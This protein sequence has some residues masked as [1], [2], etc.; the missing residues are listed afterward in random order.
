MFRWVLFDVFAQEMKNGYQPLGESSRSKCIFRNSRGLF[1]LCIYHVPFVRC[2]TSTTRTHKRIGYVNGI[3]VISIIK[4]AKY[5][6]Q[7]F[8]LCIKIYCFDCELQQKTFI[9]AL[10]FFFFWLF[11]FLG[12]LA[13]GLSSIRE[14]RAQDVIRLWYE[15]NESFSFLHIEYMYS[16]RSQFGHPKKKKKLNKNLPFN[17]K[18]KNDSLS[19]SNHSWW[20]CISKINLVSA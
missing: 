6:I 2:K 19:T 16:V 1:F 9:S 3:P 18:Y 11:M 15:M 8:L 17:Q 7:T 4:Q 14:V 12:T 20:N 10:F 13:M 5:T